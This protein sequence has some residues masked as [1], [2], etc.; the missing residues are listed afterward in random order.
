ML[1]TDKLFAPTIPREDNPAGEIEVAP[2]DIVF[3]PI[4]LS[5]ANPVGEID[6]APG[7]MLSVP[8]NC[9]EGN[10]SGIIDVVVVTLSNPT[11]SRVGNPDVDNDIG[12]PGKVTPGGFENVPKVPLGTQSLPFPL[13]SK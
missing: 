1:P 4:C 11:V 13:R 8:I 6:T 3:V 12:L 10:P 7:K 2:T 9:F 5:G